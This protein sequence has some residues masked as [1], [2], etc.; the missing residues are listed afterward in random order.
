MSVLHCAWSYVDGSITHWRAKDDHPFSQE[1]PV[2]LMN[3]YNRR[4][5]LSLVPNQMIMAMTFA[6]KEYSSLMRWKLSAIAIACL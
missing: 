1:L 5:Q 6:P 2:L 4:W 3:Y